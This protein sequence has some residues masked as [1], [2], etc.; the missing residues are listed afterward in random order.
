MYQL[1]HRLG[2][3]VDKDIRTD[4]Y[5]LTEDNVEVLRNECERIERL[6][7]RSMKISDAGRMLRRAHSSIALMIRRGEL[8]QDA[9]TDGSGAKF[10]TRASVETCA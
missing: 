8:V 4:E 3:D 2:L 5:L 1:M 10:V 7:E 6:Y 9:E